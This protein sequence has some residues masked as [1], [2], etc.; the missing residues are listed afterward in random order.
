MQDLIQSQIFQFKNSLLRIRIYRA[1]VGSR[2]AIREISNK[3][4]GL[5]QSVCL[6][7]LQKLEFF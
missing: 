3:V 2:R 6:E 7:C 4:Q 1:Y 5:V